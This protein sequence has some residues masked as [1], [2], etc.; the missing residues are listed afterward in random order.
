MSDTLVSHPLADDLL[1]EADAIAAHVYGPAPDEKVR[2]SNQRRIYHLVDNHGFPAFKLG[3][4]LCARKSTILK[5][6]E[7][8][9]QAA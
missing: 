2:K 8:Q 9:E 6:I 7:A 3:G 1:R 5:W 4:V